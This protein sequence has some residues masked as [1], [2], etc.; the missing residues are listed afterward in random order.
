MVPR[1]RTRIAS[2]RPDYLA[3]GPVADLTVFG[4]VLLRIFPKQCRP[5]LLAW[6]GGR[7]FS[8][9][10]CFLSRV[11]SATPNRVIPSRSIWNSRQLISSRAAVLSWRVRFPVDARA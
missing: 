2:Q 11:T 1:L 6:D 9:G 3:Q 8:W 10:R 7:G 5:T 4:A